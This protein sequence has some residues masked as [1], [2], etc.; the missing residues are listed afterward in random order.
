MSKFFLS[1]AI[2]T[3]FIVVPISANFTDFIDDIRS[4]L[5]NPIKYDEAL[6]TELSGIYKLEI[7]DE[8]KRGLSFSLHDLNKVKFWFLK[9]NYLKN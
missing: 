6:A 9:N 1:I 7:D 4:A 2:L 3:A 8:K 5:A